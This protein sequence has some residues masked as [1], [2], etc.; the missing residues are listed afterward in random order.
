M[1]R[2]RAVLPQGAPLQPVP[3]TNTNPEG[4]TIDPPS[5]EPTYQAVGDWTQEETIPAEQQYHTSD[6]SYQFHLAQQNR[7]ASRGVQPDAANMFRVWPATPKFQDSAKRYSQYIWAACAAKMAYVSNPAVLQQYGNLLDGAEVS[8][9]AKDG[10]TLAPGGIKIAHGNA[11]IF[12][13]QGTTTQAQLDAQLDPAKEV[14]VQLNAAGSM[15]IKATGY[16]S[17]WGETG[18]FGN[19][20]FRQTKRWMG[21]YLKP[22]LAWGEKWLTYFAAEAVANLTKQIHFVGHSAGAATIEVAANKLSRYMDRNGEML[23]TGNQDEF[24]LASNFRTFGFANWAGGWVFGQPNVCSFYHYHG[25]YNAQDELHWSEPGQPQHI[26]VRHARAT[27]AV[28]RIDH[29]RDPITQ[30]PLGL[31]TTFGGLGRIATV[32]QMGKNTYGVEPSGVLGRGAGGTS[33][34]AAGLESKTVERWIKDGD[35]YHSANKYLNFVTA[36][37]YEVLGPAPQPWVDL[38]TFVR[39]VDVDESLVIKP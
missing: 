27:Q 37:T 21:L 39:G 3:P 33:F 7:A 5:E 31:G 22:Y 29:P 38:I 14:W 13:V 2:Q 6:A 36:K 30:W 4:Y 26:D 20:V 25:D 15:E 35:D 16:N 34:S 17:F 9:I 23:A 19:G 32:K 1:A 28:R 18:I 8:S 11:T 12:G 10:P 24:N